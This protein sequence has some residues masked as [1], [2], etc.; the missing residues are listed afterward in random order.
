LPND[1]RG[2]A[3]RP[4]IAAGH[5]LRMR[6]LQCDEIWS[7]VGAKMRNASME[8]VEQQGWGDVWTWT[9]TELCA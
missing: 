8:K 5:G 2:K 3:Y 4:E 7:F 9:A 6:R 1:R